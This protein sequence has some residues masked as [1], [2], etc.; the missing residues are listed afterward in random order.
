MDRRFYWV[1]DR[2]E[3]GQYRAYWEPGGDNLADYFTKYHSSVHQKTMRSQCVHITHI[4]MINYNA[5]AER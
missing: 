1:K 3:Q 2:I 5:T 4:T